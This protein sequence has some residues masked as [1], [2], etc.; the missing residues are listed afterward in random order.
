[1]SQKG[2]MSQNASDTK[3]FDRDLEDKGQLRDVSRASVIYLLPVVG[4]AAFQVSSVMLYL[5][6]KNLLFGDQVHE[7]SSINMKNYIN[8]CSP[9]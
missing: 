8:I 9:F 7:D 1:M 6:Q 2:T 4:N 3:T 5:I